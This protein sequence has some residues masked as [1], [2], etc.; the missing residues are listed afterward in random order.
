VL[1]AFGK[2]TGTYLVE[3][4]KEELAFAVVNNSVIPV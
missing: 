2:F 3:P 1:P 4:S